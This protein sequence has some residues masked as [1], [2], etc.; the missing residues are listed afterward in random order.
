VRL[1]CTPQAFM[2]AL[3]RL[4]DLSPQAKGELVAGCAAVVAEDGQ[5]TPDEVELLRAVCD[6]LEMPLP[7]LPSMKAG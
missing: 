5:W 6:L 3:A 2:D 1:S 7:N 4:A